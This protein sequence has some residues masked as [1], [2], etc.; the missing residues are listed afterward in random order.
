MGLWS[1]LGF[2][3]LCF[4]AWASF[5]SFLPWASLSANR[6]N[7]STCY[8]SGG[9]DMTEQCIVQS[10]SHSHRPEEECQRKMHLHSGKL[11]WVAS[12]ETNEICIPKTCHWLSFPRKTRPP[13]QVRQLDLFQLQ[14]GL[15]KPLFCF[16]SGVQN[17][18]RQQ[19]SKWLHSWPSLHGNRVGTTFQ[20]V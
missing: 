10:P 1:Q 7:E 5:L 4:W 9:K 8:G 15:S 20:N 14:F 17:I 18:S 3:S 13:P 19:C 12:E 16:T 11:L 2:E 6:A